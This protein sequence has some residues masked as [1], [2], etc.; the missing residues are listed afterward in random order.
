MKIIDGLP[1]LSDAEQSHRWQIIDDLRA[2][3]SWLES[4]PNVPAPYFGNINIFAETK[5]DFIAIRRAAGMEQ[6]Q[7][8][9][10]WLTFA[11]KFSDRMELHINIEKHKTCRKVKLGESWLPAEPARL[12]ERYEWVC[13]EP[14]LEW[15]K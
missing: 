5:E 3:A 4:H 8:Y 10:D 9:G 2:L 7:S 6:K 13:D 11:H 1:I 12:V 14:L 15:R